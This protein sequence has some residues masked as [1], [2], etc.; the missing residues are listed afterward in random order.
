MVQFLSRNVGFLSV[1]ETANISAIYVILVFVCRINPADIFNESKTLI[2]LT[3]LYKE[4]KL[5]KL[6]HPFVFLLSG[7]GTRT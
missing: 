5:T 4:E 3:W 1:N 2:S 7:Y 6:T